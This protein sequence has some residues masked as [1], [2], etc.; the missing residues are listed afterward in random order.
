[1]SIS[2][3]TPY[4]FKLVNCAINKTPRFF[5]QPAKSDDNVEISE[6]VK[7]ELYPNTTSRVPI[8]RKDSSMTKQPPSK[9]HKN[10][11]TIDDIQQNSFKNSRENHSSASPN[12][13]YVEDIFTFDD[14]DGFTTNSTNFIVENLPDPK[15]NFNT[16]DASAMIGSIILGSVIVLAVAALV[17]H[18]YVSRKKVNGNIPTDN[19]PR[20]VQNCDENTDI[21]LLLV[22]V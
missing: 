7:T 14:A 9:T 10:A 12:G 18:H 5:S 6:I 15:K 11:T 2:L 20:T 1:M 13:T 22:K 8:T 3:R 19:E 4:L 17:T 16:K 21:R